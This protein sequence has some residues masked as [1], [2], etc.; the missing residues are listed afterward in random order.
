MHTRRPLWDRNLQP[1]PLG[2]PIF[3]CVDVIARIARSSC[4]APSST[5]PWATSTC[6]AAALLLLPL[7]CIW[8]MHAPSMCEVRQAAVVK[9]R[10]Q[11]E[12]V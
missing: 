9:P 4:G 3:V 10:L 1:A 8:T 7:P 6:S 2:V 5:A 12:Q 11:A